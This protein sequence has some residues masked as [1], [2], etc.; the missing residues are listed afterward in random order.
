MIGRWQRLRKHCWTVTRSTSDNQAKTRAC[1][2]L[3]VLVATW[4]ARPRSSRRRAS[5][6]KRSTICA[7]EDSTDY[8]DDSFVLFGCR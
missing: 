8:L 7:S 1:A 3:L 5:P 4:T 2:L 6:R